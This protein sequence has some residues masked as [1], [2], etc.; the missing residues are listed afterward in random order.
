MGDPIRE[1]TD[2]HLFAATLRVR[3]LVWRLVSLFDRLIR[4]WFG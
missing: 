2:G 3:M 1:D 4:S